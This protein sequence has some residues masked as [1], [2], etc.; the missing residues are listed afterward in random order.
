MAESWG[1][2]WG[3]PRPRSPLEMNLNKSFSHS[4]SFVLCVCWAPALPGEVWLE[5]FLFWASHTPRQTHPLI[6]HPGLRVRDPASQREVLRI[7][8]TREG[9]SWP[10]WFEIP[11]NGVES[12]CKPSF[13]FVRPDGWRQCKAGAT[14]VS[15]REWL[16]CKQNPADGVPLCLSWSVKRTMLSC[17]CFI[18]W[19]Q[20]VLLMKCAE[21]NLS[22]WYAERK[23][24]SWRSCLLT[25]TSEPAQKISLSSSHSVVFAHFLKSHREKWKLTI[26]LNLAR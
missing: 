24:N 8:K 12:I 21:S 17:W 4:R 25:W 10:Y 9:N 23:Q 6:V 26:H 14:A 1:E 7:W 20:P 18:S 3:H 15:C 19:I 5:F 16:K 11:R 13:E 22:C 2:V